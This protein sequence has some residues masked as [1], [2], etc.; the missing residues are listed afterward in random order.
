[1]DTSFRD[2]WNDIEEHLY[3][4]FGHKDYPESY[5]I[6]AIIGDN[7]IVVGNILYDSGDFRYM[8]NMTD[9]A[10]LNIEPRELRSLEREY[11]RKFGKLYPRHKHLVDQ[12]FELFN[13]I[14]YS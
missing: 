6:K 3:K 1:M 4:R 10:K 14:H 9:Y 5:Q 13:M 8:D 2:E 11:K 7:Y 12:P